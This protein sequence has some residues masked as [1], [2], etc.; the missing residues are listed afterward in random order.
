MKFTIEVDDFYLDENNDLESGLKKYI[1]SDVIKQINKS[2]ETKINDAVTLEVKRVVEKSLYTDVQKIVKEVVATG[3]VKGRYSGDK[4]MTIEEWVKHDFQNN[5]GFS[6]PKERIEKL[7]KAFGD[8][9]KKR[10]DL[11]FASQIVA[12][13]NNNGMLKENVAKMLLET[14]DKK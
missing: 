6:S 3:K 11:L 12:S 9:L 1:V 5:S 13:L 10:Y 8:E 14:I 4:E 2:L 7:A